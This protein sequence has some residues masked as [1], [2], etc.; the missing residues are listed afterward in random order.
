[1]VSKIYSVGL[2]GLN[3]Y[4]VEVE[5]DITNGLPSFDI[6]GLPDASV[7]ESRGRVRSAIK[8]CGFSFPV[9]RITIN[10]APA[11][12]KKE[13]PVYDLPILV[14]LLKCSGQIK[15]KLDK[16][17]FAGELSLTGELRSIN[18]ALAMAIHAKEQG[19][20]H[21]FVPVANA[22]ECSV[23]SGIKI[24]PVK[25][26]MQLLSF[27]TGQVQIKPAEVSDYEF[28]KEPEYLDFCD[29]KGQI[30]AKK[31]LEIAAAGGHNVLLVGPPGSGKSMLAKRLPS[32]LPEMSFDE[33]IETTKIY[34]VAGL[35]PSNIP[36]INRRPFRSPHHTI[37]PVGMSGGG[38]YPKPG[39]ISLAHNGI[40]F[41][42]EFPEFE[43][44]TLEI[45]RQPLE[46]GK[47]NITRASGS[48]SYNCNIMFIAAMNPCPCGY[49]GQK[50][51]TCTC[52]PAAV[53]RYLNKVSGPM[54]DR[55]DL[56]IDVPSVDY[57]SLSN[58][59]KSESSAS[60][61]QRVNAAR[62]IQRERYKGTDISCNARLT[63]ALMNKY[64]VLDSNAK[65]I[66]K[67]AFISLDLSARAYERILKVSR[68]IADLAG[69]EVI[70]SG[71]V[72][73]AVQL[74]SLE[75]RYW[76]NKS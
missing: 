42:D 33:K 16:C 5:A 44:Q 18:G 63:P 58:T 48:V 64:C 67:E 56:H 53:T 24:I 3:A 60:I 2:Y 1:M 49:Y 66:I 73:Q 51:K 70:E 20:T 47:V 15:A 40:L 28:D 75:N 54:L 19:F 72:L 55:I 27:I 34:S 52:S 23:V 43:R 65:E 41:L 35:M 74:R 17:A 71:H 37:S 9:S 7:K 21:F 62:Q 11:D 4:T 8:N 14:S 36:L 57:K 25:D 12:T 59:K 31:G 6:V 22:A 29:V 76:K 39:E 61:R 38:T 50:G 68:T 45:L 26:I 32:I 13:G 46:D 30:I 69:K 10:L